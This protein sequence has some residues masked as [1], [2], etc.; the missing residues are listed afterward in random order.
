MLILYKLLDNSLYILTLGY[1]L[2]VVIRYQ[3]EKLGTIDTNLT[4][5]RLFFIKCIKDK[6]YVVYR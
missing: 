6:R 1:L 2:F 3:T 5:E 4:N